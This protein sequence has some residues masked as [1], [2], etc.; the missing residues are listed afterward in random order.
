M[1]V[2]YYLPSITVESLTKLRKK[3]WRLTLEVKERGIKGD[4]LSV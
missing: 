4:L 3:Y 2:N 1:P